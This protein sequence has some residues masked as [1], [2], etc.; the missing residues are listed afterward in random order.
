MA[1]ARERENRL[2][3]QGKGRSVSMLLYATTPDHRP[4]AIALARLVDTK[5]RC[6]GEMRE[7]AVRMVMSNESQHESRWSA[8]LSIS[9]TARQGFCAANPER[10]RLAVRRKR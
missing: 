2:K 6:E 1:H 10:G 3:C 5:Y 8:I 4:Y 7:R 9:S